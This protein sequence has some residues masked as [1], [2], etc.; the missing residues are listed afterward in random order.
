MLPCF[1]YEEERGLS[2]PALRQ[3]A[4]RSRLEAMIGAD[5]MWYSSKDA[6]V[7]YLTSKYRR[8]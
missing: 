1:C 6:V 3:A 5:G 4:T 7:N 2:Y 8:G